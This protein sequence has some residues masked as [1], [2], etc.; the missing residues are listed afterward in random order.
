MGRRPQTKI[1]QNGRPGRRC[2][3][4]SKDSNEQTFGEE[5]LCEG[6]GD[7]SLPL[8]FMPDRKNALVKRDSG[9][10]LRQMRLRRM[11]DQDVQ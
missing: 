2:S 4:E 9:A 5:I 10:L 1:L 8:F 11:I 6:E 3:G 7:G